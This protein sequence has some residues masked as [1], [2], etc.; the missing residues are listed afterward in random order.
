[1]IPTIA[2]VQDFLKS[3]G[4][5]LYLG[6][7]IEQIGA[8]M[9]ICA[10]L[11]S[12]AKA[13]TNVTTQHMDISRSGANTNETILTPANVNSNQFGKLFSYTVDGFVYAEPL[14]MSGVKMGSGT[15]Q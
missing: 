9:G 6:S 11:A 14:Y 1:M 12:G 7:A 15:P 13:Q 2:N 10:I 5:K 4:K 8:L 3:S